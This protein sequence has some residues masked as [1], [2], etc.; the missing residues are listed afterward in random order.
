MV[1]DAG[2]SGHA[3]APRKSAEGIAPCGLGCGHGVAEVDYPRADQGSVQPAELAS[4]VATAISDVVSPRRSAAMPTTFPGP[5]PSTAVSSNAWSR[6]TRTTLAPSSTSWVAVAR[7]S[8]RD[9][10]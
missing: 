4:A 2:G 8:P 10:P 5:S 6:A 3:Q 9:A 7:P 1:A